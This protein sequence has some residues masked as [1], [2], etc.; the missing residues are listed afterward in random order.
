MHFYNK[1][2]QLIHELPDNLPTNFFRSWVFLNYAYL[3]AGIIHLTFIFMFTLI[4]VKLL[5]LF[6]IASAIIWAFAL[7]YNLKGYAKT[8]MALGNGELV[9]TPG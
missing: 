1:F 8:A 5:A 6:N 7:Y 4:G 2:Y 3:I 9:F